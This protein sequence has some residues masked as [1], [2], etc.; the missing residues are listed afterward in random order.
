[1]ASTKERDELHR[2]IWAIAN[3]LRGKVDGWDFKA[4]VLGTIFYRY[5][6]EN[7]TRY[8]NKMQQDAGVEDFDYAQFDDEG[9][10][11]AKEQ[12]V[13]EKGFF[14]LP[15]Q[16]FCNVAANAANDEN[17]NETLAKT[18]R[19]IEASAVGSEAEYKMRGL[20]S[21]FI[22]DNS[23]L[24]MTVADRNKVFTSVISKVK[25]M[26]LSENLEDNDNDTF[27]DT[28]EFLMGM[29]A[30]NAGKSGGEYFTP[31]QVSE[32]LVRIATYNNDK[33]DSVYDPACGSGS[34][35]MKFQKIIGRQNPNLK[36][37]GQE[38]NPTT[39]NL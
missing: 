21:D 32:L 6:S 22:V 11:E 26:K 27:G 15:S 19:A 39:Y 23:K 16:L 4:Y 28:Y 20:F 37:Y 8:I 35:L 24:G 25:E 18:F 12:M 5:I 29:Y 30:A 10:M 38:I 7:L 13:S 2:T 34:L 14:I 9:A 17:L 3:E 36:Y 31:Q 33:I 1:M